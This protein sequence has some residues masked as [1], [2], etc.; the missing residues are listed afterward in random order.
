LPE[1]TDQFLGTFSH[2]VLSLAS[3]KLPKCSDQFLAN[4]NFLKSFLNILSSWWWVAR[5]FWSV[6]GYFSLF[7]LSLAGD[8]LPECSFLLR[9]RWWRYL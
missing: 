9:G 5:M 6:L 7:I 3:D 8:E 1:C 4:F 2:F